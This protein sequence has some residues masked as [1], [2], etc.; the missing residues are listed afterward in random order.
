MPMPYS[1][2][3]LRL[4]ALGFYSVWLLTPS[5]FEIGVFLFFEKSNEPYFQNTKTRRCE[6]GFSPFEAVSAYENIY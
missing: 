6:Y 4:K 2:K 3:A 5:F 1:A